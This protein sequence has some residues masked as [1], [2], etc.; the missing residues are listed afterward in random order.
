MKIT[1]NAVTHLKDLQLH[2]DK[3]GYYLSAKYDIK[4]GENHYEMNIPRLELYIKG[5]PDITVN[6]GSLRF[7]WAD[8]CLINLGFGDLPARKVNEAWYTY[9]TITEELTLDEI[10][11]RLGYKIKIVN[12]K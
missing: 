4:D 3:N 8:E 12:K 9:K 5:Y 6:G 7:G 11:K 10:E 1:C 2:H